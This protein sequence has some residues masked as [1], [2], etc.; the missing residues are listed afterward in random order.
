MGRKKALEKRLQRLRNRIKKLADRA[1]ISEDVNEVRE[2]NE[3]IENIQED[4]SDIQEELSAIEEEEKQKSEE[5]DKNKGK[6]EPDNAEDRGG[7]PLASYNIQKAEKRNDLNNDPRSTIEYRTAFMN[8]VKTGQMTQELQVRTGD[9]ANASS[10]LGV[11]IPTTVVQEIVKGIEKVYGQLYSSVR[12]TNLQGGVKYPIGSFDATFSRITESTKS[13]RQS[14]GSISAYVEFSYN[15]GEIRL[16]QTLL[17]N[18]LSVP[19]FEKE[20]SETIVKAYVKAMDKEIMTGASGN[21]ECEGILTEAAKMSGRIPNANIIEFTAEDMADWKAW[22]EKLFAKIPLKMRSMNPEFVMTPNTY[23][24]NIKTLCDDN[25]RPVFTE[26][27]NPVDGAEI[28]KFKGKNVTFVE[29]DVLENF[30]DADNGEYFG[31][32]W[33]PNMAYAIN[34][35][36]NFYVKRYFDDET[37]QFV[38]K[39]L[40]VNDGKIL[41][42]SYLYLL[43]KKVG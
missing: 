25:N 22:Q 9:T 29:D 23:E 2:I 30:N 43:K 32:Y 19:V 6:E 26:T 14:G 27:F 20:L 40:V 31:M 34:T 8:Y 21:N 17:A 33:V 37:N 39:A 28:S 41:D 38:E 13:Y 3:H 36:M 42:P 10:D 11:L 15:I 5:D 1:K 24:A 35:N 7:N 4:I 12:K 16:S 18:I